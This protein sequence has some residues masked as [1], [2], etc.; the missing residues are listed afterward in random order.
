[1]HQETGGDIA[2]TLS[3]VEPFI[4]PCA[5]SRPHFLSFFPKLVSPLCLSRVAVYIF[6]H[7]SG[8]RPASLVPAAVRYQALT[9]KRHRLVAMVCYYGEHYMAFVLVR[10]PCSFVNDI[11]HMNYIIYI[12]ICYI[13]LLSAVSCC[14]T[15]CHWRALQRQ[16]HHCV[17]T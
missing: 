16:C 9:P 14:C 11:W 15:C 5:H 12:F 6:A 2:A 7:C 3:A 4:E 8:P 13:S 10:L 17:A 1:M